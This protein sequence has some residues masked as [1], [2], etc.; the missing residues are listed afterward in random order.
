MKPWSDLKDAKILN[1]V[2]KWTNEKI[3]K[4][5]GGEAEIVL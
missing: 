2:H 1:S 4:K 5:G 3:G